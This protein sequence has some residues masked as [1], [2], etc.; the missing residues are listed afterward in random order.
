MVYS[1]CSKKTLAN[2]VPKSFSYIPKERM[3][4]AFTSTVMNYS[5]W[6]DCVGVM[7]EP[8][9]GY[10]RKAIGSLPPTLWIQGEKD[11]LSAKD[12]FLAAGKHQ[13][14]F[15]LIPGA[16]HLVLFDPRCFDSVHKL[17]LDFLN[18]MEA[19]ENF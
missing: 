11:M 4:R 12:V 19:E 9:E 6:D 10:Y 5:A 15:H 3:S 16:D 2:M 1:L 18:K 13:I 17:I 7:K 8:H 14:D